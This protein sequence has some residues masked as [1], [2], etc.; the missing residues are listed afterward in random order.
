M[1]S[2]AGGDRRPLPFLYGATVAILAVIV[3]LAT[4]LAHG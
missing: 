4:L 1:R 3:A 2:A